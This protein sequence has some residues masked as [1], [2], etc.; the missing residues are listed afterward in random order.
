M[1]VMGLLIFK[2]W[3]YVELVF[4]NVVQG[5]DILLVTLIK[6]LKSTEPQSSQECPGADAASLDV[7]DHNFS[8]FP[9]L[10][11]V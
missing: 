6:A 8:I 5:T 2:L 9:V 3:L 10:S 1:A 11:S 7:H 4:K